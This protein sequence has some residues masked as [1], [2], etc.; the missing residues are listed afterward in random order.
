[1]KLTIENNWKKFR[2]K[3]YNYNFN[4]ETG[5][6]ER[7]G[8][9]KEDDPIYSEFG[10]EILDCEVSTICNFGC[11][12]CYKGNTSNGKHMSFEVFKNIFDKFPKYNGIHF[13]TQIAFGIG[14]IDASDDLWKMMEYCRKNGVV[15]NITIN[16]DRLTNKIIEKLVKYCGAIAVSRYVN[17]NICYDAIEKLSKKGMKQINIHQ[18][19]S[20][21]TFGQAIETLSDIEKDKRLEKLNAIVF[22][23]LK[24]KGRGIHHNKLNIFLF[25]NLIKFALKNRINF[26]FDSCGANKATEVF[27][28]LNILEKYEQYIEPCESSS[29]SYYI[30]V[31]GV[32]HPCSFSNECSVGVDILKVNDFKNDVWFNIETCIERKRI[33]DNGRSCPYFK[34]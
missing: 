25:E 19:I 17:K 20:K 16:G 3:N 12:F 15:P 8:K 18:M 30:D 10:P 26:G 29:F 2:S 34:V 1:M 6:F 9:V 27:K 31:N 22:L 4:V 33:Q 14:N 28:K 32:G 23:S 13:L 11:P 24:Q 7:W 21:E 5:Y